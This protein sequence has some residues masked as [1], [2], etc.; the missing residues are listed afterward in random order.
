MKIN[1]TVY[2]LYMQNNLIFQNNFKRNNTYLKLKI[3][4]VY[5]NAMIQTGRI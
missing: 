1:I 2:F 4:K 3:L 5:G